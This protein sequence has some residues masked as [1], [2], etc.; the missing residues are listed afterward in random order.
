MDLDG[1]G[2]LT[3]EELRK[4]GVTGLEGE[5]VIN[6]KDLDIHGDGYVS[7]EDLDEYFRRKH[8]EEYARADKDK[9]GALRPSSSRCSGSS[10]LSLK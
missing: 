10:A 1:N 6:V 4:A 8:R 7:R 9:D 2:K 5:G 3:P